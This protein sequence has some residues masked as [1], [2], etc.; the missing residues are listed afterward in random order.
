M[1]D[2]NLEAIDKEIAQRQQRAEAIIGRIG[3]LGAEIGNIES[4]RDRF[5]IKWLYEN[6]LTVEQQ[7]A[8]S[9]AWLD[10]YIRMLTALEGKAREASIAHTRA[11]LG[12]G[13]S[14]LIIPGNVRRADS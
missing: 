7:A 9:I 1:S 13:P 11:K 2:F 12:A 6:V 14:G 5:L 3:K 8:F 10:E 4:T